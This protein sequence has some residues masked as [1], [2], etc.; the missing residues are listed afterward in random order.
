MLHKVVYPIEVTLQKKVLGITLFEAQLLRVYFSSNGGKFIKNLEKRFFLVIFTNKVLYP[1][2]LRILKFYRITEYKILQFNYN[3]ESIASRIF[4]SPLRWSVNSPSVHLKIMRKHKLK[5]I[6]PYMSFKLISR[7]NIIKRVLRYCLYLTISQESIIKGFDREPIEVGNLFVTSLTNNYADFKI[8][9]YYRR[10]KTPILGTIRSWD[11]L[12]SHGSIYLVPDVFLSHSKWITHAAKIFQGI[13]PEKIFEWG[14]PA[15]SILSEKHLKLRQTKNDS[16]KIRITYAS[17]AGTNRD[18]ANFIKWLCTVWEEMPSNYRLSILSHPKFAVDPTIVP[19]GFDFISFD[20]LSSKLET[21][22]SF[23]QEQDLVLCGGTSVI[24][25]CAF[26]HTPI[27]LINF[28]IQKQ[29]HWFSALRYFDNISH[30]CAIFSSFDYE[31]ANTKENLLNL[32][33]NHVHKVQPNKG[34]NFFITPNSLT[35]PID[36]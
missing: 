35:L 25:D 21:Y 4:S 24:L 12:T 26:T 14:N 27:V 6:I 15:Y 7:F 30:S 23:L 36:S 2:I 20:F 3:K 34:A 33:L 32:I 8:A 31:Y 16:D 1:E 29:S 22:Y 28:E 13:P 19:N 9:L 5:R 10:L 11:N 17:M 18:D